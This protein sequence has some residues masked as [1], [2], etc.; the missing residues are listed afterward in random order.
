MYA[1]EKGS[2]AEVLGEYADNTFH[3][4]LTDPPYGL[5]NKQPTPAEILA[6]LQGAELDTGGDFMGKDWSVPSVLVWRKLYRVLRPGGLVLCFGS[7][8]VFDLVTLGMR[9]A[10]FEVRDCL[11][12]LYAKGFPKSLNISKALDKAEGHWRGRA[13]KVLSENSA[14]SAANYERTP[15]G[16]PITAAAAFWEGYGT[17]LKPGWEPII[18]ARKPL[19][20]TVAENVLKWGCGGLA[21][22]ACRIGTSEKLGRINNAKD[23]YNP[24]SYCM[25]ASERTNFDTSDRA[26]GRY[27]ANL[28]LDEG[29]GQILDDT[30]G[31]RPS[32]PSVTRNGGGGGMLPG[33]PLSGTPR[34]DT[35]Y[36]DSGG[37]SRFF[38]SSKVNTKERNA[39]CDHLPIRSAGE[40]TDREEDTQGLESSRAGAGRTCGARNHHP[41]LKPLALNEYL[42]K[43]IRPPT[44]D[45]AILVPYSGAGSEMIGAIKAGWPLV[46]GIERDPDYQAIAEARL[47][48]WCP[49]K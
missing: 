20:G 15:K 11:T 32:R 26:G 29:A 49:P 18:L 13:G 19:D 17:A 22:D 5:G 7:P 35:G 41:T 40:C 4:I 9:M 46:V 21:I 38:F 8:R 25:A 3:A 14:M 44:Q 27:P 36:S 2:V 34:P 6:Y 30:V 33:A 28:L 45:A 43:L 31:T 16:E 24:S 1:I 23:Q 10:G 37:P 42:A 47:A 12:W 39:G 48:H